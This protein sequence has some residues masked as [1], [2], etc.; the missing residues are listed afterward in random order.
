MGSLNLR[1]NSKS[2]GG[3]GQILAL[4]W[5]RQGGVC[6]DQDRQQLST[7]PPI[8]AGPWDLRDQIDGEPPL[9][10]FYKIYIIRKF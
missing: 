5:Q 8:T 3:R 6:G 1:A 9:R 2:W 10:V 4:N 7:S